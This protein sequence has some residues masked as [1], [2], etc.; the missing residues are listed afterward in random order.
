MQTSKGLEIQKFTINREE[1]LKTLF[2][3]LNKKIPT[4]IIGKPGVGKTH[5][6]FKLKEKLKKQKTPHIYIERF[7]PV[8][9]TLI[10]LYKALKE[11]TNQKEEKRIKRLTIKELS[12]EIIKLLEERKNNNQDFILIFDHL[13]DLTSSTA[14]ILM[15]LSSLCLVFG[16]TQFLRRIRSLRRFFWQFDLLELEPLSRE[17]SKLL[18]EKLIKTKNLKIGKHREFFINQVLISTA[19]IPLSIVETINRAKTRKKLTKNYIRE[20]FIHQS[21]IK[22]IDASPFIILVFAL[23]IV[24]R[25]IYR[26]F[27]EYQGYAL[28]GALTGLAVFVRFLIYKQMRK[29]GD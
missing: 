4:L 7:K 24:M 25:F 6:L 2:K 5:L 27:G 20:M 9:E 1:E 18:I 16:A 12:E 19:G 21:G 29:R 11:K 23:F 22:E 13:E 14:D 8:K 15:K 17:D 3:N 26:G 10:S 28:F